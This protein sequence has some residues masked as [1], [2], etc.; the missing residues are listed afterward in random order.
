MPS[1]MDK[2][3]RESND[4]DDQG[5][6]GTQVTTSDDKLEHKLERETSQSIDHS[7]E[8]SPKPAFSIY[9]TR[10]KWIIIALAGLAGLFR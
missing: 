8:A 7:S 3:P 4:R 1:S 9:T 6:S 2:T 5:A 10:E